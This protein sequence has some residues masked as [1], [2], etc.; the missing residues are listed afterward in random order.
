MTAR[1]WIILLYLLGVLAAG[2]VFVPWR[3]TIGG[4]AGGRA[5]RGDRPAV[6]RP[7]FLPPSEQH[8]DTKEYPSGVVLSVAAKP[9]VDRVAL[10]IAIW[11][12]ICL[13]L[14]AFFRSGRARATGRAET[15]APSDAE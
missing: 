15:A 3:T 9:L 2:V 13:A 12:L 8:P 11:T 4:Y 1:R 14:D 7:I 6:I 5:F 10:E